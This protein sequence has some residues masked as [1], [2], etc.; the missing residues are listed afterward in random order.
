MCGLRLRDSCFFVLLMGWLGMKSSIKEIPLDHKNVLMAHQ[1]VTLFSLISRLPKRLKSKFISVKLGLSS[2]QVFLFCTLHPLTNLI[3]MS[4][5]QSNIEAIRCVFFYDKTIC[6][7]FNSCPSMLPACMIMF[8]IQ[9]EYA[10]MTQI[11]KK[12]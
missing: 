9:L 5:F 2:F 11:R 7:I 8:R 3:I 1:K 4:N 6:F 10:I 12:K